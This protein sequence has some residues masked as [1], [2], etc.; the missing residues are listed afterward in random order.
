MNVTDVVETTTM[1]RTVD[2]RMLCATSVRKEATLHAS[3]IEKG[4][5]KQNDDDAVGGHPAGGTCNMKT[6]HPTQ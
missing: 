4:K 1:T 5:L 2:L 3:V 6:E